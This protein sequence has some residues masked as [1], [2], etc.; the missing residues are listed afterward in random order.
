[1]RTVK[2]REK[3]NTLKAVRLVVAAM[4]IIAMMS[5]GGVALAQEGSG[6]QPPVV[7]PNRITQPGPGGNDDVAPSIQERGGTAL[8]LTGSDLT[9]FALVGASAVGLGVLVLRVSKARRVEA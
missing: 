4:A 9:M 5:L 8:P 6:E 3:G 1:M 7:E 2:T